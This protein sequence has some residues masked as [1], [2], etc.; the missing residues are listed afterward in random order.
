MLPHEA[1]FASHHNLAHKTVSCKLRRVE[2]EDA[3]E[4]S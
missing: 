3:Q 4:S 1:L 2:Y